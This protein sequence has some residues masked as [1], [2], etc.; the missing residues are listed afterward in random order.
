MSSNPYPE[1]VDRFQ[2][3][4]SEL[5][6]RSRLVSN[7][8]GLS[9]GIAVIAVV[10]ATLGGQTEGVPV[11][12]ISGV[13][14]LGF[15]AWHARVIAA[16]DDATRM[17]RVNLDALARVTSNWKTLR[18]DGARFASS[19]HPYSVDLDLFGAGSL[20][21]RINVAHT[22]F[23]QEALA[24]FL[25]EPV[26]PSRIRAR[27]E[28]VR[29]LAPLLEER[30][31][32]EA[33]SI[34]VVEPPPGLAGESKVAKRGTRAEPP[35]PAALL[36]WAER[37]PWLSRRTALIGAVY[38]L[39]V[40]TL[41]LVFGARVFGWSAAAWTIPF[42]GELLVVAAVRKE[43]DLVFASVSSTQGAFLRYGPMFELIERL[44][45]KSGLLG[46]IRR[47]LL[48]NSLAPSIAMRRFERIVGWF[49]LR[50]NG[51]VHPFAN[52]FLLWD[53][54][55][56]LRLEA[57]QRDVGG[58]ARAWFRALGE[59]EALSAFAGLS[60]DEPGFTWPDVTDSPAHYDARALGHPLLGAE[61]RVVNDV[62]LAE[63][64]RALLVTG[65]NMSGKS[66]LLRAMGINAVLA[67]AGAPVCAARLRM[68]PLAVR[69]SLRI[70]DSLSLG[71]SHFYAEV[72]RLKGVRDATA[73]A[74]PVFFLLDE[75]LHGTNSRERQ[76]GARWMLEEM[77]RSGAIGA[78][79]THDAGLCQ[80]PDE[81]MTRV[82]QCHFRENIADGKMTFDYRL[83][84]G[85][86]TGGNALR[87]MRLVGLDVPL[88]EA[89]P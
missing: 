30:Q 49:D 55:C 88:E 36:E 18:D 65:S 47:N 79:S 85:P 57:W 40:V 48:S 16:E 73:G 1:R 68:S 75:I 5:G 89:A 39:P 17:A 13:L 9:F 38:A 27:Q 78:V 24:R 22:R 87:L 61:T 7:L 15:V 23:G 70:S 77:L 66:T 60:F 4:A 26:E 76:I 37:E 2:K 32:L 80:L 72:A 44:D 51:L 20:Y 53:A 6:R 31:R 11:A 8:R 71:V 28:A 54:H 81:L 43:A 69:T 84:P 63:P 42:L 62:R 12:V 10:L 67:L 41:A 34:A 29:M 35:D 58:A 64:G 21:Q 46:E 82:E 56:L 45:P 19:E 83:R 33:L 3:R 86:V 74:L 25:T 50:Y 14:F 59:V 52:A